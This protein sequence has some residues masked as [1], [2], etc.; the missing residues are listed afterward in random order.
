MKSEE[1]MGERP[2]P[3]MNGSARSGKKADAEAI[4][5]AAIAG[6][7][8][9]ENTKRILPTLP[10]GGRVTVFAVGK[11]AIPQAKA[12]AEVLGGRIRQGLAV[13]KYG[14]TGDFSSPYFEVIEAAHP[15]SD[16]NSVR[17]ALRALEIAEGLTG[18]DTAL[19]LLSGGGSALM[20]ASRV[21]AGLQ[22]QI[23]E[24][25]LS[26]GA[27]IT[28]INAVRKRLS[29]VKGGRLAAACYPAKVFTVALS[30]VLGN[31]KGVI[32]SGPTVP[33]VTPD[34][35]VRLAADKYLYDVPAAALA[36]MYEKSELQ[37][38]DGGYLFAGDI[39]MLTAAAKKAAEA[40]GYDAQ[41]VCDC[42]TGEARDRA[43][44][45]VSSVDPQ[46]R[47]RAYIYAGETTVTLTGSGKGGRNQEMALAAAIAL[48]GVPDV[49]FAAA[50][51]DGTDGPTDAAGGIVDG[52]TAESMRR[53]GV[54]PAAALQNND[55]YRA[56]AAAGALLVTGPTGTNVNDLTLVL[57]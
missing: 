10:L 50:G 32:A 48:D 6:A 52:D 33:D 45:I 36:C 44:E 40:L 24:K 55:S 4:I 47:N 14:H 29:L 17:A 1:L 23:T 54:D 22:R 13:T 37:I 51:S 12:A 16:Q 30:D 7:L 8:P 20:E 9:Y 38:N 49:V 21:D 25:L 53:A 46:R 43:K 26:R 35:A 18:N 56:L 28:E 39:A 3:I 15:V 19:V 11:A 41:I 5:R 27:D 57:T 42:L 2:Y 31:D 34:E